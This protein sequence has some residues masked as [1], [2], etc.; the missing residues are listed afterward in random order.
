[1]SKIINSIISGTFICL[2]G[3]TLLSVTA[4][5]KAP[6]PED[7]II[8]PFISHFD[9]K[10]DFDQYTVIDGN[11]D[12]VIWD[13]ISF[14]HNL[15]ISYNSQVAMDDW[16]VTPGLYLEA[17][18]AYRVSALAMAGN[19]TDTERIEVKYGEAPTAEALTYLLVPP[20]EL[21]GSDYVELSEYITPSKT[22]VYYIGFH[23]IS[24][25]DTYQL[26]L[27]EISV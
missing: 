16:V 25:P 23:G 6:S 24:D 4:G 17:G 13:I 14:M 26:H 19:Y 27:D 10:S 12:G 11:G 9:T 20:T 2:S 15:R 18:K 5:E 21:L 1:M 3:M 22:G 7:A 8:P